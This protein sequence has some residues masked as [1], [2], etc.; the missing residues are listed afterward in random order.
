MNKEDKKWL[1]GSEL[2]I[3]GMKVRI[4]KYE[5]NIEC[6]TEELRINKKLLRNMKT[7]VRL[8]E[9]NQMEVIERSVK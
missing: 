6:D 5:K 1:E 4:V 8:A 7:Q 9:A 3:E 2:W